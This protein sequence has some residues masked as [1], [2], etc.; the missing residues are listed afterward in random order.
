MARSALRWLMIACLTTG[1]VWAAND[2]FVGKWKLDP[3]KSKL[4]DEMKVAA[5]GAN[6]Y[7]FDFGSGQA[8]TIVVDGTDQPG[9]FGTTLSV[10]AEAPDTWKVV[11]KK[12]GRTMLT[13]I[14]KLSADGRNLTDTFTSYQA[15]G[16]TRRLDYVYTRATSGSGFVG[17]WQ[18]TSEKV[19][20]AYE[21]EIQPYQG[22]G[23]SFVNA[24]QASTLNMK[25][26]GKDY[27]TQGANLPDGYASSGQ[28]VNERSLKMTHKIQ[29]KE[30]D[31]EQI[32]VSAD[33][34]TL[35]MT[36]QPVGQSKP[37]V[38]VFDRE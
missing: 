20:S 35:T 19:E 16:S 15:N 26:D 1:T 37:N 29:G 10:T 7:I 23:L 31:T 34:N 36:V 11:R 32:E 21:I 30:I 6:K 25:F 12:D 9:L 4:S 17:I 8:E 5:A 13:G 14:W 33:S 18:S 3:E 24:A 2:P 38:L 28:R 22:D 27:P